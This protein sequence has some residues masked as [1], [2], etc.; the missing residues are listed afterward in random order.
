MPPDR[1]LLGEPGHEP[2]GRAVDDVGFIGTCHASGPRAP[3]PGRPASEAHPEVAATRRLLRPR[4]TDAPSHP[5]PVVKLGGRVC[6]STRRL[7]TGSARGY[8]DAMMAVGERHRAIVIEAA[9]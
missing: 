2:R 3:A 7:D 8:P 6:S 1:R 9:P 5:G 4:D